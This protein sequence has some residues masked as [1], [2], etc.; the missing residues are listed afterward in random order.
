MKNFVSC[1]YLY[2]NLNNEN[3]IVIDCR[4][5][6]FDKDF[7]RNAYLKEHIQNAFYLDVNEDLAGE[8]QIHGGARPV[9]NIDILSNKLKHFGVNNDSTIILYDTNTY[10]SS[11]A[12]WQ[13]KNLGF[14][15]VFILNGGYSEWKKLNYPISFN[16]TVSTVVGDFKPKIDNS[17]YADIDYIKDALNDSSKILIDSRPFERFTG[18]VEPLYS[19]K[20][21]IPTSFNLHWEKNIDAQGKIVSLDLLKSNFEFVKSYSEVIVYCGSGIDGAMNFVILDELGYKARLYVGSMSDWI[22][23]DENEVETGYSNLY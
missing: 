18:E 19:K 10:S 8:V 16:S 13:L 7:G 5:D 21:H 1:E 9:P 11:R 4:F 20:G 17:I 22:S 23:Y 12:F 6:L 3:L 15:K 2:S 14:D